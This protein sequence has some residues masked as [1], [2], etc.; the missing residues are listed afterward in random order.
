MLNAL[1][2]TVK[3][4]VAIVIICAVAVFLANIN[5]LSVTRTIATVGDNKVT[6]AE[7]KYYLE[8]IKEQ[9]LAEAGNPEEKD[10][11]NTEIDGK[12]A[13]EV[14][15]ERAMNEFLCTEIAVLKAKDAGISLTDEQ[16]A[17]ARSI[18]NAGDAATKEQVKE[19][20][21]K[22][23]VD[24]QLLASIM[25]KTIL[26][27]SYYQSLLQQENTPIAVDKE[28]A[29][30]KANEE[31]AVVKHVLL[32]NTPQEATE[33]FDADQYAQDAQKKADEVLAKAVSGDNFEKLIEEYGQDP[34]MQ[35]NHNGY[36]I[37]STGAML[38]G[39]GSM[40]P[41][42]TQGTFAVKAGEV[43]PSLVASSYGW[44]IIKRYPLPTSGE[45]Y[46]AILSAATS[47]AEYD[48]YQEYLLGLK[49][50]LNIVINE[51]IFQKIKVK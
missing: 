50:G 37:D 21:K 14:A 23:G 40:I 13:S 10:F 17:S 34:G 7:Y 51:K 33:E 12:K 42:F 32:T 27:G 47:D 18:I 39:S 22:T 15:K 29:L 1:K 24:A 35:S 26:S 25:E 36:I 19:L 5:G 43:N 46:E 45:D 4:I 11:W 41:E 8:M 31:F 6:E 16:I 20:E 38:D 44:H 2:A 28:K 49:D 9:M 30:A 3:W 48:A